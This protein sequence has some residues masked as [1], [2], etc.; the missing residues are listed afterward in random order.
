MQIKLSSFSTDRFSNFEALRILALFFIIILHVVGPVD[1]NIPTNDPNWFIVCALTCLGYPGVDIFILIG[2]FFLY[3]DKNVI[4]KNAFSRSLALIIPLIIFGFIYFIY[5]SPRFNLDPVHFIFSLTSG[6]IGQQFWFVY[7]YLFLI[8]LSPIINVIIRNMERK[9]LFK[10]V[11]ILSSLF[12][13]IPTINSFFHGN[14]LY[15][16]GS[17]LSYFITLYFVAAYIKKYDVKIKLSMSLAI[18]FISIAAIIFLTWTYTI[19][20]PAPGQNSLNSSFGQYDSL[21]VFIAAISIFVTFKSIKIKS[22]ALNNLGKSSY[23][24][25]LSHVLIIYVVGVETGYWLH[26]YQTRP[27]SIGEYLFSTFIL[28]ALVLSLSLIYGL[29]R[30]YSTRYVII[31]I[32]KLLS[33]G[34]RGDK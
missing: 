31:G 34:L 32:N 3:N 13:M 12:I 16:T 6:E 14:Y 28:M 17:P 9:D 33:Y 20:Y 15:T 29:V 25:Y 8:I 7:P 26:F 24:A 10:A 11:I 2:A 4:N 23:D 30:I 21:F 5:W 1:V 18:Y 22:K 27:F 19:L